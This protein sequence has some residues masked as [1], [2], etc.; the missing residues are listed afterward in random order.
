[1]VPSAAQVSVPSSSTLWATGE[2]F[3]ISI[4]SSLTKSANVAASKEWII[5]AK[6]KPGRKPKTEAPLYVREDVEVGVHIP[7]T[8][9]AYLTDS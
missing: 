1:M 6:P 9:L 2:G 8:A 5:P 3:H 4:Y 7:I